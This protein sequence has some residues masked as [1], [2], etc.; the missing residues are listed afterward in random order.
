MRWLRGSD[1]ERFERL[2]GTGLG[3][4]YRLARRLTRDDALAEDLVQDAVVI[5]LQRIGQLRDDTAF[6]AWL[7]R[8]VYRRFLDGR[9]GRGAA[10]IDV[11]R[12]REVSQRGGRS[13]GPARALADRRLGHRLSMAFDTLPSEQ[14]QAAWLVDGLGMRFGEAAEVLDVPKGTVASRVARA[15]LALRAQLS[16]DARERGVIG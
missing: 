15:R 3:D 2:L 8:I 14:R 7:S 6:R 13:R 5:G 16:A 4:A 11:W 9:K 10:W 12:E 1:R